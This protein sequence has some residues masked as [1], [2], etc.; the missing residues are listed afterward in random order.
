[1]ALALGANVAVFSVF[2]ALRLRPLPLRQPDRLVAVI[3]EDDTAWALPT[4]VWRAIVD[5]GLFPEGAAA[6]SWTRFDASRGGAADLI[7]GAWVSGSFF[8]V[9]GV[10]PAIGRGFSTSDDRPGGGRDGRVAV[11]SA[12]LA[13]ARFPG[14]GAVGQVLYLDG[15]PYTIVGVLR[16]DFDGL[17]RGQRC[18]VLA[19]IAA[20]AGTASDAPGDA[21]LHKYVLI[22]GRLSGDDT[23]D[24][25]TGRLRANHARIRVE[26]M[27]DYAH[28]E[29]RHAY[30]RTPL[31]AI[32][33]TEIRTFVR[34]RY[35]KP[36]LILWAI[37]GLV[38]VVACAN[39]AYLL[40]D[41]AESRRYETA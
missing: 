6:W 29:D 16:P 17:E 35:E 23:V 1:M 26:T 14:T 21:L 9:A 3:A 36:L 34:G 41:R 2:N 38:L 18:D 37:V 10:T 8:S 31:S 25:V 30:L 4:P 5:R 27:P 33:L 22:V 12:R 40:M 39:V 32:P 13:K 24:A 15:S 7:D 20:A 19:P 11:V 28:A